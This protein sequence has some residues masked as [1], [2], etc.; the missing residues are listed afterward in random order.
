MTTTNSEPTKLEAVL[1]LGTVD[2]SQGES[3]IQRVLAQGISF[4]SLAEEASR[5]PDH[6]LSLYDL[7]LVVHVKPDWTLEEYLERFDDWRTIFIARS[8]SNYVGYSYM[9][10]SQGISCEIC[11]CMTGV[12]PQNRRQGIATAL[13]WKGISYA[14]SQGY[15]FI[16]TGFSSKNCASQSMNLK[17][18]FRLIEDAESK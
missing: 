6:L 7:A 4:T 5:N 1:D 12:R 10:K 16:R 11:Q 15:R 14:L 17:M 13:K 9:I 3:A 18:G 2:L 8:E